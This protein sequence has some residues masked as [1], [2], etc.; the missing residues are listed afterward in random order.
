MTD[1]SLRYAD[2]R[3]K[4]YGLAGMAITLVVLDGDDYLRAI[5]LDAAPGEELAMSADF[6]FKGNPRMSAKIVWEQTLR[7]LRLIVSMTLGNIMCRRYILAHSR[8]RPGD[9]DS[10]R[11]ALRYDAG[12]HCGLDTDE[13]DRLFESCSQ[14]VDRIFRHAEVVDVAH[15]FAGHLA[16]RRSLSGYEAVEILASLGLK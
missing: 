4:V 6:S 3:D 12:E 10:I 9:T 2:E 11:A 7:D 5:D 13:A 15:N 8:L 16:R 1:Y 14:Y